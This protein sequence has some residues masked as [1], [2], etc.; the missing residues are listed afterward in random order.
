M[1][2]KPRRMDFGRV[3]YGAFRDLYRI[4]FISV[5]I[6]SAVYHPTAGI[7]V[8]AILVGGF[9]FVLV[10]YHLVRQARAGAPI[11]VFIRTILIVA[12]ILSGTLF[13]LFMIALHTMIFFF[14]SDSPELP[15]EVHDRLLSIGRAMSTWVNP[16]GAAFFS[17]LVGLLAGLMLLLQDSKTGRRHFEL[18]PAAQVN[19]RGPIL[20]VR[21]SAFFPDERQLVRRVFATCLLMAFAPLIGF[22]LWGL[23]IET[24]SGSFS[25]ELV[26]GVATV[27]L[28]GGQIALWW[29][30]RRF[31]SDCEVEE[32]PD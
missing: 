24:F 25:I 31:R 12:L 14:S 20:E 23:V 27:L 29:R 4:F 19:T 16:V 30:K 6:V 26:T 5:A 13:S 15:T 21:K 18:P 10:P 11:I 3:L 32:Y 7:T 2:P 22:L 1:K 28:A 8:L 9:T 17:F